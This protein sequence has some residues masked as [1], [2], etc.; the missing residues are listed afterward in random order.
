MNSYREQKLIDICFEL[1]ATVL[2]HSN[3]WKGKS[4]EEKMGWVSRQLK[5]CGFET[6][7]CGASW[8]IL[9]EDNLPI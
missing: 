6:T 9:H 5:L 2:D 1:V 4:M 7:P 3:Y 8:G